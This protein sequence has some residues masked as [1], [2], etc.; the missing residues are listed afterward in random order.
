MNE[1][2]GAV[3]AVVA[4]VARKMLAER[5]PARIDIAADSVLT[6]IGIDSLATLVLFVRLEARLGISL[7]TIGAVD[8][9]LRKIGDVAGLLCEKFGDAIHV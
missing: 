1:K 2:I 4:E 5:G 3:S 7:M 8:R 6:E 9:P